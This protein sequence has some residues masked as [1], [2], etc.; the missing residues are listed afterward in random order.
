MRSCIYEG[1]VRHRRSKP[2]EHRFEY[3]LW[4]AYLDLA[5]LETVFARRWL[6]STRWP[7]VAWFRRADY[8]G[9]RTAGDRS[10]PLDEAVRALVAER[11]GARPSGPIGILTHLRTFG[12][13]FNPVSFYYCW[14]E[15]GAR[16]E[17]I[18]A[19]IENTPW[20]ERHAYVL[21]ER[22]N[23]GTEKRKR[24]RFTKEFHVS[25]FMDM[26]IEYDWRF[27][28]PG[29]RLAVSMINRCAGENRQDAVKLFDATL[30]LERRAMSGRTLARVLAT[31]P[32]M[33]VKVKA[34]I[35]WNAL[36]L[37]R[38]GAPFFAHPRY[39]NVP[40]EVSRGR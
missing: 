25:P 22:D 34:A 18:V 23:E 30:A 4:L 3:G 2:V 17:T 1:R 16:V 38:K 29:E 26:D 31:Y 5:E 21:S 35:Y 14:D 40:E 8:L 10:V 24:F 6:W 20:R 39:R 36:Q 11:T 27:S 28:E 37:W 32:F 9:G 7:N 15:A 13:C 12:H 19:E 33:T